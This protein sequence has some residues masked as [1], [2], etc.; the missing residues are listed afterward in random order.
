MIGALP[1]CC[2]GG[3][4]RTSNSVE[5]TGVTLKFVGAAGRSKSALVETSMVSDDWPTMRLE[6]SSG[7]T[8]KY[9]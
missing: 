1:P 7:K 9:I 3:A 5:D 6:D 4:H 2:K 8:P